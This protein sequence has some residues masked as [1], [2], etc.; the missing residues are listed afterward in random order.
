MNFSSYLLKSGKNNIK[1]TLASSLTFLMLFV[2]LQASLWLSASAAKS[3]FFVSP[4]YS[5]D[6]FYST[7]ANSGL[8]DG[9][10]LQDQGVTW[11]VS[12]IE[13]N[14][15]IVY[16]L[17]ATKA[18]VERPLGFVI[19]SNVFLLPEAKFTLPESSPKAFSIAYNADNLE[20]LY[21]PAE[22]ANYS[23]IGE[24]N[25]LRN[26]P[27]EEKLNSM[28]F[29]WYGVIAFIN[30]EEPVKNSGH[31]AIYGH[32]ESL[33]MSAFRSGKELNDAYALGRKEIPLAFYVGTLLPSYSKFAR[34]SE[35]SLCLSEN[36]TRKSTLCV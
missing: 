18:C 35:S 21:S 1:N 22:K 16:K 19:S 26:E 3:I 31:S 12:T 15:G 13:A 23:L 9:I 28:G 2:A 32:G 17:K 36:P 6:C 11:D 7:I 27:L 30:E 10:P 33:D 20:S 25:L 24:G 5:N 4:G 14:G 34:F 8:K 29:S